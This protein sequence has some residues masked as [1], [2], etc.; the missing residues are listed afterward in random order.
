M[1]FT[2]ELQI[3]KNPCTTL[4]P[5]AGGNPYV[6]ISVPERA[7][8]ELARHIG[9]GQSLEEAINLMPSLRNVRSPPSSNS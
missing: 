1:Q 3:S 4:K 9:K 8:I 5:L 6:L 7:L 2:K